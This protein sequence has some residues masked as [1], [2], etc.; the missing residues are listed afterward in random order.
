[1]GNEWNAVEDLPPPAAKPE[2]TTEGVHSL[3]TPTTARA[4][5]AWSA[6][7]GLKVSAA[8]RALILDA[9]WREARGEPLGALPGELPPHVAR[10]IVTRF[11]G[12]DSDT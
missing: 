8:I 7:R 2:R 5:E 12:P 6:H 4:F 1:M 10:E 11:R 9:L 3:L